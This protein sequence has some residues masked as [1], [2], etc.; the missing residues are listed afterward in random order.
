MQH[1]LVGRSFRVIYG[2]TGWCVAP[3]N[4]DFE[5]ANIVEVRTIGDQEFAMCVVLSPAGW[6]VA[7]PA[8]EVAVV[9]EGLIERTED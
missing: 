3:P 2:E 1:A 6:C 8:F 4:G 7:R 5:I 9:W